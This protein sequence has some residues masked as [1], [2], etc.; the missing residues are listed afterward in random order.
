M[1]TSVPTGIPSDG[2]WKV[3]FVSTIAD[4]AAP[5]LATEVNATGSVDASCLLTK[6]GIGFDN[7]YEK[8]KDERLCTVQVFEQNGAVTWSVNDLQFVIDPQTPTSPTNK[9]YALVL[10]GWNGF[11]VVRMGISVDSP[12]SATTDKVWVVPVSVGIP[13]PYPPEA[14]TML[15]A[16]A[17]VS[18]TGVIQREVALAA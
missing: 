15:R 2:S 13:V 10:N 7:S 14:N 12:W 5:K 11:L 8:F 3:A 9:L 17:S 16:K 1:P 4:P 18:V 6:G